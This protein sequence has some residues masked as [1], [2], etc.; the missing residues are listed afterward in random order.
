MREF[1]VLESVALVVFGGRSWPGLAGRV[2]RRYPASHNL[3]A[4]GL[5]L[6]TQSD[7]SPQAV[8]D[9]GSR[10]SR[11]GEVRTGPDAENGRGARDGDSTLSASVK[12]S[13][14]SWLVCAGAGV[15]S[16]LML[17]IATQP[18]KIG[19]LALVALVPV[20]AILPGAG[21]LRGGVAGFTAGAIWFGVSLRW[22]SLFGDHAWGA[23]T[24]ALAAGLAIFGLI[25]GFA[26]PGVLNIVIQPTV[27]VLIEWVRMRYP[28]GGFGLLQLGTT[29]ADTLLARSAAIG[30]TLALSG[31][32][33]SV[34]AALAWGFSGVLRRHN[35]TRLIRG[36]V[37]AVAILAF[38]WAA[39]IISPRTVEGEAL[40]VSVL[41]E[42]DQNRPLSPAEDA[43]DFLLDRFVETTSGLDPGQT[44]V[45]WPEGSLRAAVPEDDPVTRGAI[46]RAARSSGAWIL[47]NGQPLT[48]DGTRFV[49]RNYLFDPQGELVSVSDKERL[50]PFGEYIPFR[51]ELSGWVTSIDRVGID[52]EPGEA[53]SFDVGGFRIGT[54]ICFESAFSEPARS[55]ANGGAGVIV[56]E[57]NNRSFERSELSEQHLAASRM[58]AIETGRPV[59]HAAI[60]G[61]SA[62][63]GAGGEV[64]MRADLF[65][66]ALLQKEI[67]TRAGQTP[68]GATGDW[69]VLLFAAGIMTLW[70][71]ILVTARRRPGEIEIECG[72]PD[73]A[74][75]V[76]SVA[77]R[78]VT[79]AAP[80]VAVQ[81]DRSD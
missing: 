59:I 24:L 50:V 1:S 5:Q 45:I 81:S 2:S 18:G 44:L 25:C 27:W 15:A 68:Y 64:E 28:L 20:C 67:V 36:L 38:V 58:R 46:R 37:T 3:E 80:S 55:M 70:V 53:R 34:N 76:T 41:Q 40:R 42:Y 19:L 61:V 74:D 47:A 43:D 10:Q 8:A 30:G 4:V 54:I 26:R 32:V 69:P 48:P 62:L 75:A 77:V 16:G 6:T 39:A 57:T 63:I 29:Q 7:K 14:P 60:S 52:G 73:A 71:G 9:V 79:E 35:A 65:E 12:A 13:P 49:N 66:R 78:D 22:A 31:V 11:S 56:V 17:A 23:L 72:S 33:V 21:P 51:D